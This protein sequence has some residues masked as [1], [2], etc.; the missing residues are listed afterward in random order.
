MDTN[1]LEKLKEVSWGVTATCATCIY[2]Q[3]AK[4]TKWG[5][6]SHPSNQYTHKKHKRIHPLPAHV[7]AK[8]NLY[9]MKGT[10][11]VDELTK[12]LRSKV[13]S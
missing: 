4:D 5:I 9:K 12:F 2:G 10:G 11:D 6:C 1:K 13:T 8:C 3:F 7:N